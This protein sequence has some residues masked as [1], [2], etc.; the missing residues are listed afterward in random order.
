MTNR[1]KW[2]SAGISESTLDQTYVELAKDWSLWD[3]AL[4]DTLRRITEVLCKAL[5]V[6]RVSIWVLNEREDGFVLLNLHD[7]KN[8]QNSNGVELLFR[9]YPDYFDALNRNRVID[10]ND[11]YTDIRTREFSE[12]YLRPLGI[13]AM[14][15]STLRK[16]GHLFGV[17]CIEHVG[18]QRLWNK[19]EKQFAMSV[20]DLISQRMIYE[21]ARRNETYYRELSSLQQ[22]IFDGANYSIISTD[23]DGTIR[24]FNNAASRMLGYSKEE[25]IGLHTP[26]AFHD[27]QEVEVRART[28]S[29]ELGEHIEPGFEVFVAKARRGVAEELEWTYIRKDGSRFP[30]LLSA[31]AIKNDKGT[32]IGFL[33]IAFDITDHV[34]TQRA[35]REE[36]AR[37]RLLFEGAG[38]SLF[39]MKGDCF[40]D[41]NPATLD[42]FGCTR[43]QIL[44]E[45]PYRYSP[46]YQ[47]DGRTSKEKALE[48]I[49]G[50]FLGKKQLFEWKHI[51]HDGTPFDAEVV[52]NNIEINGEQ[53]LLALVRDI[54]DRKQAE[55]ELE[56][57]RKELLH[58]NENL[59]LINKLSSSLH[60]TQS[61]DHILSE[62]MQALLVLSDAPRVAI[63]KFE[64]SEST[65]RLIASNGFD[66]NSMLAG[67]TLPLEDSLT[68]LALKQGE[69]V[70][71]TDFRN[72]ERL[73]KPVKELLIKNNLNAA[74]VIP[75]IYQTSYLGS[76]NLIYDRYHTFTDIELD[77]FKAI[78]K[79]VSIA[80][81]NA[82]HMVELEKMAHHDSLTSLPN[83]V[84][85]HNYF[86]ETIQNNTD[87]PLALLLLDLDRFKEIND[88]LGHHIG[89]LLL[90]KIGPRL[91]PLLEKYD[92]LLCRLGGDE[93][94]ILIK[95]V[96]DESEIMH[97]AKS[98]LDMLREPFHIDSMLLE[99]DVSL[100]VAFYPQDGGDS[101]ALLRSADVAMYEAKS[102]GMGVMRYDPSWDKHTPERLALIADLGSAIR[103]GQLRLHYQPKINLKSSEVIGFEALVRWQHPVQGLL[104]PD[105][106]IGLAEVSNSIHYLTEAVLE[107]ALAQQKQ[108]HDAGSRFSIAVNLSARNLIDGRCASF[109][110]SMLRKYDT[111]PGMLELE[112]TETALMN[113]PEG[114]ISQINRLSQLGVK[115]SIDDFGTGYSSLSYLRRMPIDALKIDQVFVSHM[116]GNDLDSIIVRSTIA[117]AHNLNL[118]VIAEGV[119]DEETLI[120]LK[121]M[122]CDIAQGYHIREPCDWNTMQEWLLSNSKKN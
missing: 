18:G 10:A 28:L 77:T 101:H 7:Q 85:L 17:L 79:T 111:E 114:S 27:P 12:S 16:A 39:L 86:Q 43:E 122:G 23:V 6:A 94:T 97:I 112:I 89:D 2:P 82:Q 29:E 48:K 52:L 87:I 36:E 121:N 59:S 66:D 37:Y 109:V 58:R 40:V 20:T 50:A 105:K 110:E 81:S 72:D 118:K 75:L 38:D 3:N 120:T 73:N 65:L 56:L 54:S 4:Q 90:Q 104:E 53:H 51:R 63:Y 76:L 62:A 33:G 47:P 68:G 107:L 64:K 69:I 31:T 15:D 5:N 32:I 19:L 74:V 9:D 98:I 71:S 46:E 70:V 24:S 26:A 99:I 78:G 22:A 49:N 8:R 96:S 84:L 57:S 88:T 44:N 113:D 93:F 21:D 116:I 55:L 41:C 103:E 1:D 95:N 102:R 25:M 67:R 108:W 13:S 45:T 92:G 83:R 42:M 61:E 91:E 106:F 117:L 14:L 115:L 34:L 119:E 100:G 35:L 80:L 30:V 60:G 11:V